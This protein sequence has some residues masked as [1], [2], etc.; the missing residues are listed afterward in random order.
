MHVG[1]KRAKELM[2]QERAE[3]ENTRKSPRWG[4]GTEGREKLLNLRMLKE[5][6]LENFAVGCPHRAWQN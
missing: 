5:A 6:E 2:C 4:E 1:M 3:R